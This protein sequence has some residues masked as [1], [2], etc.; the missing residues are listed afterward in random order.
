MACFIVI[1]GG[2][3]VFVLRVAVGAVS[4]VAMIAWRYIKLRGSGGNIT[5]GPTHRTPPVRPFSPV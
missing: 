4:Y 3:G 1:S 2:T 5:A